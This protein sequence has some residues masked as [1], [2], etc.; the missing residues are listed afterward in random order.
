M[1]FLLLSMVL[2]AC[3]DAPSEAPAEIAKVTAPDAKAV[4]SKAKAKAKAK[5][6]AKHQGQARA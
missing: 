1:R 6:A 5:A 2:V 4:R 3:G